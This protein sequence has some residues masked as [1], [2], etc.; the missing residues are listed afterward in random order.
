MNPYNY[1]ISGRRILKSKARYELKRRRVNISL[2]LEEFARL[3][4]AAIEN[5]CFRVTSQPNHATG[6]RIKHKEPAL[7]VL[8]RKIVI[9]Y[10]DQRKNMSKSG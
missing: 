5:G 10:L 7:A 4:K 6:K 2:T 3:E 8:A 1:T 9:D